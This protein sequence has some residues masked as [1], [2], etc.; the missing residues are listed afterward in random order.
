MFPTGMNDAIWHIYR[1]SPYRIF[2]IPSIEDA[3]NFPITMGD[4]EIFVFE[5]YKLKRGVRETIFIPTKP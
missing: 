5:D 1:Q 2:T 3:Y 4:R